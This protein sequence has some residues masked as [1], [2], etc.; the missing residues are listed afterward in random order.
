MRI[1]VV[2][3][4]LFILVVVPTTAFGQLEAGGG[5]T[6]LTGNNGLDGFS[7]TVGWQFNRKVTLVGE[8]DFLWDTSK[9]G[10]FE[11]VPSVGAVRIKSNSQNY[12]GGARI[13]FTGWKP[14]K[15]VEKR[16]FHP[17]GEVLIGVSRLHQ[18]VSDTQGTISA[19][20]A[21]TA[22]TWALG[23]GVDYKLSPKWVARGKLDFVRTHFVD[24]GQ[25]QL[26]IHLGIAYLF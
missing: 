26:R 6:H 7:G 17:F 20:A 19:A 16:K 1:R 13:S 15:S 11:L 23:G 4:V 8:G 14:M 10:V 18:S 25:S 5:Y 2:S 21:D 22:F 9:A 24:A 3:F 12:L